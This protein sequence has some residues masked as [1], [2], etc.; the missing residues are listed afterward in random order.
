MKKHVF[1]KA[2]EIFKDKRTEDLLINEKGKIGEPLP[3]IDPSGE[4]DSWFVPVTAGDK[5]IG[6]MQFD[7]KI[8][9][10]RYASFQRVPG[11]LQGCPRAALWL[12]TAEITA[13]AKKMTTPEETLSLPVLSYDN[14]R[15][16]IVWALTAADKA[17]NK[18]TIYVAGSYVYVKPAE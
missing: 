3:V 12:D 8:K 13:Q 10:L 4:V 14:H 5:I 2:S 9:F 17:G 18:R 11:S 6:F 15:T 7:N 1:Q 16:R